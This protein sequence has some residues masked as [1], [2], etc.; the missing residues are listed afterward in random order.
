[1]TQDWRRFAP[2]DL[3]PILRVALGEFVRHGYDATSV[4]TIAREVGVTVPALYYHFENKQAMLIALLDRAMSIVS[5]HVAAALAEAGSDPAD[6]LRAIVEAIV[7]YMAHHR[8]LAQLDS[9]RRSLTEGNFARY[10]AHRDQIEGELRAILEDGCARGVFRTPVPR[11]C[12]R[13]ILAMCQGV[14]GWYRPEGPSGP[15][16]TAREYVRVAFAAV[17]HA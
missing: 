16:E 14:A 15:E 9:E 5:D 8:D 12:G 10:A 1:M 17:E 6:R 3:P 4:R 7:L 13:A 11:T 2:L